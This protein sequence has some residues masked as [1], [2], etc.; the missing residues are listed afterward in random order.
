ME[1]KDMRSA[2]EEI[3]ERDSTEGDQSL[4]EDFNECKS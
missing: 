3:M 1:Y 2:I 4:L